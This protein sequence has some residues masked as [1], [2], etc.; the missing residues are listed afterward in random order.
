MVAGG[1]VFV[2]GV[3]RLG[4]AYLMATCPECGL[5]SR[6]EPGALWIEEL[7]TVHDVGSW[8]LSGSQMKGPATRNLV[9]HCR[10]GWSITGWI[11]GDSFVARKEVGDG[12]ADDRHGSAG[13]VHGE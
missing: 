3:V 11:E 7:L 4:G 9:L 2:C 6:A 5:S 1:W 8:L 12:N 13:D 10:C